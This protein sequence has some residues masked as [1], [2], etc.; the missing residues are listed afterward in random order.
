MPLDGHRKIP[1]VA[2]LRTSGSG[3]VGQEANSLGTWLTKN[4]QHTGDNA[5]R[6]E[7]G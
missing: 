2:Y 4:S 3:N 7:E 5:T 1:A 6:R